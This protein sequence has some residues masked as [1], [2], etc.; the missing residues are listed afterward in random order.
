MTI[1]VHL[2]G[3]TDLASMYFTVAGEAGGDSGLRRQ[4]QPG[5]KPYP[6]NG[7]VRETVPLIYIDADRS[8]DRHFGTSKWALFGQAI[9]HLERHFKDHVGAE[10]KAAIEE[11]LGRA[12]LLLE[13]DLYK[14]FVGAVG[15]AFEEQLRHTRYSVG[16]N[17]K[18]FDPMS[19]YRGLQ[20]FLTEDDATKSLHET[21]S[22]LRN[23]LVLAL[24]RAFGQTFR[25]DAIV[26][27]EEPELYL[28]PHAQRGLM[29]MFREIAA[30]G[31]QILYST[32]SSAFVSVE[33]FDEVVL[34]DRCSDEGEGDDI[35]CTQVRHLD[36]DELVR[37]HERNRPGETFLLSGIRERYRHNCGPEHTEA[38]FG[39]LVV[40]VEGATEAVALPIYA[41]KMGQNF[42]ALGISVVNARGKDNIESLHHLYE[43]MGFLVYAVFDNDVGM[44]SNGAR[45]RE[46]KALSNRRLTKLL[47]GTEADWPPGLVS[48]AYAILEGDFEKVIKAEIGELESGLYERLSNEAGEIYG[49]SSKPIAARYIAD[50]MCT[51]GCVPPTIERIINSIV[52]LESGLLR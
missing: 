43:G 50:Y 49:S 42:D 48:S 27:I 2:E 15:K 6:L 16:V 8:F 33:N 36:G 30:N 28:H 22:G 7:D 35:P 23:L 46:K 26:A 24:F 18:S 34:V 52:L 19:F 21:G 10:D 11:N 44:P 25:S 1:K 17:F 51:L 12:H 4:Y 29:R 37:R 32:H 47:T 40:L 14:S 45:D 39:R 3:G 13:T 41:E 5:G 20:P 9:R 38:F 31:T